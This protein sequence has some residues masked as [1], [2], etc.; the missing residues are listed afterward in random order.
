M[1]EVRSKGKTVKNPK[2]KKMYSGQQQ[3][4]MDYDEPHLVPNEETQPIQWTLWPTSALVVAS[5]LSP[6]KSVAS[7]TVIWEIS[8]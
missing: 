8:T 2:K 6:P 5:S 4:K 7:G 1:C 3:K